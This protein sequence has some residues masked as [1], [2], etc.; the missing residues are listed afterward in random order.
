MCKN[1]FNIL[2]DIKIDIL[3]NNAGILTNESLT[4]MNYES[5][6]K[7]FNVNTL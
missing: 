3:I 5:I 4:N 1:L 6:L 2:S 7:Q